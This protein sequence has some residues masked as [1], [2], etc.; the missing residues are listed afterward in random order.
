M[1]ALLTILILWFLVSI[2]VGLLV[3]RV[4]TVAQDDAGKGRGT[5][6]RLASRDTQPVKNTV[7]SSF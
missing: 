1:S 2:V 7:A 3:G 5:S 4:F 6:Q